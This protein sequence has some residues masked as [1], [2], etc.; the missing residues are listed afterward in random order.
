MFVENGMVRAR[1]EE[2]TRE[3]PGVIWLDSASAA[4]L[5]ND[6]TFTKAIGP[7]V[8]FTDPG[9]RIAGTVD[10]HSLT[11]AVGPL[12]SDTGEA[13][14]FKVSKDHPDYQAIQNR[15]WE[16]SAL[17]RDGIE[18][19][20]S[21]SVTF[22]IAAR[23]GE[24]NTRYGFNPASVMRAVRDS[25]TRG[26]DT[27]QPLWSELPA[28]MAV[29]VWR[30]YVRKF[31]QDELFAQV[32]KRPETGLQLIA[33][34]T[35][36][37]LKQAEIGQYDDFGRPILKAQD[38]CLE[39]FNRHHQQG[40]YADLDRKAFDAFLRQKSKDFANFYDFLLE[41]KKIKEAEEFEQKILSR[42]YQ[43]LT[44][45]GWEVQGV[46]IKRVWFA[47]EIEERILANWTTL[48]KKNAEKGRDQV[49]RNRKL[50]EVLGQEEA[51]KIFASDA[52]D[53]DLN[54]STRPTKYDILF[55]L[56]HNTFLGVRRNSVLLKRAGDLQIRL[57]EIFGWMREKGTRG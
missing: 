11:Q 46:S 53:R 28:R 8:H 49:E 26:A 16:T 48:W 5:R 15:R 43:T 13:D 41:H 35:A 47:P 2:K 36:K 50:A 3:G 17:T 18:V 25:I 51:L 30:E 33:S 52:A 9:E 54:F 22:H 37:R 6:A 21:I 31:R 24:G 45:M 29:D 56:T 57:S 38:T 4:V 23:P 39:I 27:S 42:E 19:L 1:E 55:A 34:L 20:A 32:G 40:L 10:L 44:E 12:E 7:G 14:P